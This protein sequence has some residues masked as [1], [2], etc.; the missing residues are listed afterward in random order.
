MMGEAA[1]HEYTSAGAHAAGAG[2]AVAMATSE[3]WPAEIEVRAYDA[4][5]GDILEGIE[6]A[7][8][9]HETNERIHAKP[10]ATGYLLNLPARQALVRIEPEASR[11]GAAYKPQWP[12]MS[13]WARSNA[14]C[15]TVPLPMTP[16]APP[17]EITRLTLHICECDH[18]CGGHERRRPL[19][20]RVT[21]TE[22]QSFDSERMAAGGTEH[23]RETSGGC[24]EFSLTSDRW[25]SIQVQGRTTHAGANMQFFACHGDCVEFTVCCKPV[26]ER[27]LRLRFLD[28]YERP[29]PNFNFRLKGR[30]FNANEKGEYLISNPPLGLCAI[31]AHGMH[32]KPGSVMVGTA[33]EQTVNVLIRQQ[34]QRYLLTFE[35]EDFIGVREQVRI[36]IVDPASSATLH[37]LEIDKQ[38]RAQCFVDELREYQAHLKFNNQTKDVRHVM[39]QPDLSN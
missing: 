38:G 35:V 13:I 14:R 23:H 2:T 3:T 25:Y 6:Y 27:V 20:G 21:V 31:E 12:N 22:M 5:S 7:F 34:L 18:E 32:V 8:I 36:A 10:G 26:V 19:D 17:T 33:D 15:C 30:E 29:Y 39:P 24:V 11:R 9:L 4:T 1:E 37:E 16:V 28:E